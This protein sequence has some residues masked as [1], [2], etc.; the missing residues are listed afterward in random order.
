[1]LTAV[2]SA[3][4]TPEAV[5]FALLLPS[6]VMDDDDRRDALIDHLEAAFPG[7]SFRAVQSYSVD[8]SGAPVVVAEPLVIP[9]V[10]TTGSGLEPGR[11]LERP[12]AA[13]MQDIM[14]TLH[15]FLGGPK[16]LS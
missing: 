6:A 14:A 12:S 8:G 9:V 7:S 13:R 16:A 5:E 1:M 4:G 3:P 15:A 10:G 11:V 2:R